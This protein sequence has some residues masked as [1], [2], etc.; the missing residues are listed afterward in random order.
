MKFAVQR[1]RLT[2]RLKPDNRTTECFLSPTL[3]TTLLKAYVLK[4]Y[5]LQFLLP[6]TSS[7]A[8]E[9][10]LQGKL[11]RQTTQ[12]E[13]TALESG[14][15]MAR[16]LELSARGLKIMINMLRALT[17]KVDSMQEQIDNLSREM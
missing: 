2:R 16:V 15:D 13:E 6:G 11:K 8:I 12:S 5:I 17:D 4:A 9:K 3:T 14:S 10:K 7:L 1:H